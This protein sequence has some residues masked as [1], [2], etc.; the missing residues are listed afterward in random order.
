MLYPVALC[1]MAEDT[2]NDFMKEELEDI[3]S[4]ANVYTVFGSCWTSSVHEKLIKK[5][6]SMIDNYC[7]HYWQK[8]LAKNGMYFIDM[9][10]KCLAQ[11]PL[12]KTDGD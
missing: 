8:T 6:Q 2:M 5:I 4:F 9:C 11:K 12:E 1:K 3:L 10:H 7:E